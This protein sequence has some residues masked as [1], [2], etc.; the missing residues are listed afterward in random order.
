M[1]QIAWSE[2]QPGDTVELRLKGGDEVIEAASVDTVV[3]DP[4][5]PSIWARYTTDYGERSKGQFWAS[6][7]DV[8]R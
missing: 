4:K 8:Y 1:R 6:N 2:I 7:Y 5:S 3:N